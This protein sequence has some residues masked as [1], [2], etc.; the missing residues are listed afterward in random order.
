MYSAVMD[1]HTCDICAPLDGIILPADDPFWDENMPLNHF[2]CNC[3]VEQ[4]DED[5]VE[6]EGGVDNEDEVS[7]WVSQSQENKN[8]LFNM[9]PGKDKAVF[10]DTGRSKHPYFE[11]PH[12]YRELAKDNFNLPIPNED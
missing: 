7:E 10:K 8:P 6:E 4:L 11:V 2:E 12:Q 5:D 1:D 9:N 3:V